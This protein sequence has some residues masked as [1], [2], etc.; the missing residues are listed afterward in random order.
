MD[1]LAETNKLTAE[2]VAG[3]TKLLLEDEQ[4]LKPEPASQY[5][6]KNPRTI[7]VYS[8]RFQPFHKGHYQIYKKLVEKFGADNVFIAASK[9][10]GDFFDL[11]DFND[12][13]SLISSVF[14]IND[15]KIQDVENPYIPKELLEQF[16]PATTA[17]IT[18]VSDEAIPVL[19]HSKYFHRFVDGLPLEP[20][21]RAGYFLP[22]PQILAQIGERKLTEGQ[23]MRLFGSEKLDINAKRQF[24][25]KIF[26]KV[27]DTA[28]EMLSTRAR[29]GAAGEAD[30]LKNGKAAGQG[31]NPNSTAVP[32]GNGGHPKASKDDPESKIENP[33]D[34][35]IVN[36]ETGR[37]IQV[38]SA[39]KYPR[40]KAVYK[41]ADRLLKKTG[42]DRK[43]R[44]E[45]PEVNQRY[46]ARAKSKGT[47][48]ELSSELGSE[49]AQE[50]MNV[51]AEEI[52]AR[53][54]ETFSEIT[55][56]AEKQE[57]PAIA[58]YA[59]RFQP[60]HAGH[61]QAYKA[62]VNK[63][64]KEN[65]F[66]A[67]SDKVEEGK[68]PF[69]FEDKKNIITKMFD[70]D[71]DVVVQVNDP[72]KATEITG[73]FP[74]GTP[75]VF[76]L[77]EKDAGR[78]SHSKHFKEL[79]DG[80]TPSI[81]Y[82]HNAYI[83]IVPQ[84]PI[85]INGKTISGEVI[86]QVFSKGSS[87]A[88]AQLFKQMYGKFDKN[89]F[90]LM[91]LTIRRNGSDDSGPEKVKLSKFLKHKIKNPETNHEIQLRTALNYDS[92]HPAHKAAKAF[93]KSKGISESFLIEGGAYGHLSHP[94]ED[95][96]LKFKDLK[97]MIQRALG[98][99]LDSEG[100][101]TEKTDGQNIMFTV[102]DG[103]V[104]F[105]RSINQLKNRG[106][107]AMTVQELAGMFAGR[108]NIEQTFSLAGYDLQ[109][110]IK[111]LD[112]QD[113]LEIFDN[114]KK[115][116][117]VE[118][119]HPQSENIIPYDKNLL[120]LHHTIEYNDEGK[121]IRQNN[122]DS[123]KMTKALRRVG[124]DQQKEFGI[125]GQNFIVF[126][127]SKTGELEQKKDKYI[128]EIDSIIGSIGLNENNTIGDFRYSW[129]LNKLKDSNVPDNDTKI[130]ASRW[131][132]G[133]KKIRLNTLS[134]ESITLA[135]Q[136]EPKLTDFNSE[137]IFPLQKLFISVGMDALA[138]SVDLL[139]A[140]NPLAAKQINDKLTKAITTIQQSDDPNKLATVEK[141]MN[142]LHGLE[143]DKLVP[144]E[145]LLFMYNGKLYKFTGAFAPINKIVGTVK[146]D[147]TVP[148]K[149]PDNN[150]DEI[151]KKYSGMN[152]DKKVRN[153]E[154]GNDILIRT[155]LK[156]PENH[157]ARKAA[158]LE[159]QKQ[160]G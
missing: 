143:L 139:A 140:T 41:R 84:A 61:F 50:M 83:M 23:I 72:Y 96:N 138:R 87:T 4:S 121:P 128:E 16:D 154:T 136:I 119:I 112:P 14:S 66:I 111:Y 144:S 47:N 135:K 146:F 157:P 35:M 118:I 115:F 110:S 90:R 54:S 141:F 104:R 33:M 77:G 5:T 21:K 129:W 42:V 92:D 74:P 46:R 101:V 71:P 8:G 20:F 44:V 122:A 95:L 86:R 49:L 91:S 32:D 39:L 145:G 52:S 25:D 63:F 109:E 117:S 12:K 17:F 156:Y 28:L 10:N 103:D 64:G 69:N 130:L 125:R 76:G 105:A 19:A 133:N 59:G 160:K 30:K 159:L 124:A 152:L 81:G 134:P 55:N 108:G 94:Y 88:R 98:T 29:E 142:L 131:A 151:D 79:K 97:E 45:D 3:M 60:F 137:S 116:M 31:K 148:K 48:E 15:S 107:S 85:K 82:E 56:E 126:N 100:P 106:E 158:E 1:L 57:A 67:T 51:H 37:K 11:L 18:V 62:L 123:E 132:L 147:K 2:L 78:L 99:G 70:I 34:S 150:E 93:L 80:E 155:A 149:Q 127:N 75:V 153:P 9:G 89:L 58:I 114:G 102:R 113:V 53:L 65:V 7:A 68:S 40:W 24:F 38:K 22:T 27:N 120:I 43:D 73:R 26:G 6:E 13:K 36:P